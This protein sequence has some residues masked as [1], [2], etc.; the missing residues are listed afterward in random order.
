MLFARELERH[1]KNRINGRVISQIDWIHQRQNLKWKIKLN[2]PIIIF[3][4]ISNNDNMISVDRLSSCDGYNYLNHGKIFE[5]G[6]IKYALWVTTHLWKH[7]MDYGS[8][9]VF[10]LK[11]LLG[12]DICS[13]I[14]SYILSPKRYYIGE[15]GIDNWDTQEDSRSGRAI[16]NYEK[17][18]EQQKRMEIMDAKITQ[19]K[20]EYDQMKIN[21]ANLNSQRH[22]SMLKCR[23]NMKRKYPIV[24][25]EIISTTSGDI[26]KILS[27]DGRCNI[28]TND[29]NLKNMLL[30]YSQKMKYVMDYSYF[31]VL[32]LKE[33][34]N[35]DVC[36]K[37]ILYMISP[38]RYYT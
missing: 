38:G 22:L 2:I 21:N 19:L 18:L 20:Y 34:F 3:E 33:L 14:I 37:I 9:Y 16:I 4:V 10:V 30:C 11:I 32:V 8:F 6:Y 1:R 12:D 31:Y 24:M 29:D 27:Y 23:W 36:N 15:Q 28:K 5:N 35:A 25:F 13:K 17:R 26:R 7:T